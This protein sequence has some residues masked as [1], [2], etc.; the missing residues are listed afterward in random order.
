M[1]KF[2]FALVIFVLAECL[3]L[4][5]NTQAQVLAWGINDF[6]QLG[7]GNMMTPQPLPLNIGQP[8]ITG[9]NAGFNHTIALQ[10][11]GTLLSWGNNN[12]GKLG[13]N[14]TIDSPSPVPVQNLT[15]VVA[16]AAGEIHSL[17]L[18]DDGTVW[19]WGSNSSG[20]LGDG[21]NDFN[22][23]PLPVQ[24][25]VLSNIIAISA[26]LNHSLALKADG[27]VWA[28]GANDFGQIGNNTVGGTVSPPT[29]VM[30]LS[31]VIAI[32]AGFQHNAALKSDGTVWVWG[33]NAE[34]E[35]GN[36][37]TTTTGCQCQPLPLQTTIS[38]V[39][40]IT[41]GFFNTAAVKP[42]GDVFVWGSNNFG[43]IG[44]GTTGGNLPLPVQSAVSNVIE[45][46]MRGYHIFARINDGSVRAWGYNGDG[47][48]GDGTTTNTGCLCQP[49]PVTT[50]VGTGNALVNSGYFYGFTAK[51]QF[52][53]NA[54]LNQSLYGDK[55]TF[56]FDS[57]TSSGT[58]S[59][60]AIDPT[61]TGLTVP[62]GY[63]IQANQPAYNIT[64]T[65]ATSGNINVCLE[66]PNVF[67][68][69]QFA[70]LKILHGEGGSLV[71]RTFSSTYIRRRICSRVTT[72]SPF[73]IALGPAPTAANVSI[74]GRVSNSNGA[75]IS[76]ALVS[77][78][79]GQGNL[80]TTRT[81]SFGHYSFD[82]VE[83]GQTYVFNISAKGYSFSSQIVTLKDE[84]TELNFIAAENLFGK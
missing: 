18:K 61:S 66:V 76:R 67:S 42:N 80:R 77:F 37:T 3:L 45:L 82:Q 44:N 58:T 16:V 11:N 26:H 53:T 38:G 35:I 30:N 79:D 21:T 4:S 54:G 36:N 75:G 15:G 20:Q 65:A 41:A 6:G 13:N 22:P 63:T 78:T 81:N 84:L 5:T 48:L 23:H 52:P 34:G 49:S 10:A 25:P 68:P 74:E 32:A 62:V 60:T 47:E 9:I 29:Q 51:P 69:S 59:Y 28:W 27:T 73:V 46:K 17:A 72:L 50:S 24:V 43:Q 64:T 71:D 14:S 57:V 2:S 70:L 31:N 83:V 55:V 40:Q 8:Q 7:N 1:K 33:R 19:V 56:N 39:S 12:L